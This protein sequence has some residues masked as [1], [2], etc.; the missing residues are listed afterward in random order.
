MKDLRFRTASDEFNDSARQQ[1]AVDARALG[2][3]EEL[4]RTMGDVLE[5]RAGAGG[6]LPE[7]LRLDLER[8]RTESQPPSRS[9][10]AYL[11]ARAAARQAFASAPSAST[12]MAA[13]ERLEPVPHWAGELFVDE[14]VAALASL[15]DGQR[16][17]WLTDLSIPPTEDP[18]QLTELASESAAIQD[19]FAVL[20]HEGNRAVL[21]VANHIPL[22]ILQRF[23]VARWFQ[24][25][26]GWLDPYLVSAALFCGDVLYDREVL[27]R[28]LRDAGAVFDADGRPT[29]RVAAVILA[30]TVIAHG[31]QLVSAARLARDRPDEER[32][33]AER[34][35]EAE[36]LPAFFQA[37]WSLLLERADGL[38]LAAGLQDRLAHHRRGAS[39]S[40][41]A[42]RAMAAAALVRAMKGHRPAPRRMRQLAEE[43]GD[44]R[45][46][47]T[48]PLYF[49][50]VN[51]L[52]CALEVADDDAPLDPALFEWLA[53]A[54]RGR[55]ETWQH[56]EGRAGLIDRAAVMLA[57]GP[58]A[59]DKLDDLYRIGEPGCR[60][61]EFDS[62][63]QQAD[64]A[65]RA[66]LLLAARVAACLFAA[67]Q[68]ETATEIVE[69]A[70]TKAR[71]LFL[72]SSSFTAVAFRAV[73]VLSYVMMVRIRIDVAR[74]PESFRLVLPN[75]C[76][77]AEAAAEVLRG[78]DQ[79]VVEQAL[80]PLCGGLEGLSSRAREWAAATASPHDIAA[81]ER[82]STARERKPPA[83]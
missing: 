5:G 71:R 39:A 74:A 37:A 44:R 28:L 7:Q 60:R 66:V 59:A 42:T 69:N 45:A 6:A 79:S 52:A 3:H 14:C 68:T 18:G 70:F 30:D 26:D 25:V 82:L 8:H 73:Q 9:E 4:L 41:G 12:V 48:P 31:E 65:A 22:R 11:L 2:V 81:V 15:G 83:P 33:R 20:E 76:Q 1:A 24:V 17:A 49:S 40:H 80:Q 54:L 23:D 51:A 27:L 43:R 13:R 58:G 50:T 38:P 36:E 78:V 55:P 34:Q 47:Q 75:P 21:L 10:T 16:E 32:A 63:P 77:A 64:L 56:E 62:G 19:P 53:E 35:L 61:A 72:V 67:G 57:R 29:G 46:R